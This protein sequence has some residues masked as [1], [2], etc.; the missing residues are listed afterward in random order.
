[1]DQFRLVIPTHR[2]WNRQI[3]LRNLPKSLRKQT[4]LV[5][6]DPAEVK[7]LSADW[8]CVA[9][10]L[11]AKG[12]TCI[13]EKRHWIMN[14]VAA[15]TV[16]MMDDDLT[17]YVRCALHKREFKDGGWVGRGATFLETP[18][19]GDLDRVFALIA[20]VAQQSN[21]GAVGLASRMGNNRVRT[22]WLEDTRLMHAFGVN[23]TLYKK[24]KLNFGEVKCREDFNIALRLLRL[25]YHNE[26]FC[27]ACVNPA[28]YNAPG[29]A[30]TERSIE[31]SNAEAEK[32]ARLHPG[33][34][35]VVDK[36]YTSSVPRKEV[37]I[38]WKKAMKSA[39]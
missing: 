2:R 11:V 8:P 3:T 27:D 17:F 39:K 13:A 15:E 9:G 14:N 38:Q 24:H 28:S 35:R 33:L 19:A 10:I 36:T 5:V 26:L 6:S 32:L 30:S 31:Q 37:V 7:L 1:M 22:A 4:V 21:V 12:T 29:G 20:S 16:F 34:V 25:G 18:G 23:R